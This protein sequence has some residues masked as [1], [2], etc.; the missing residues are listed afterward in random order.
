L[1]NR[2]LNN[3]LQLKAVMRLTPRNVPNQGPCIVSIQGRGRYGDDRPRLPGAERTT[4][5]SRSDPIAVRASPAIAMLH[6]FDARLS[7]VNVRQGMVT[8]LA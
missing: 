1:R 8:C 5:A 6:A 7:S 3:E 4:R 2:F